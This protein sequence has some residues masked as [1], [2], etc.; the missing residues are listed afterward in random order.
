MVVDSCFESS[1]ARSSVALSHLRRMGVDVASSVKLFVVTH[2]HNDH[3]EGAAEL[4]SSARAAFFV[5]SAALGCKEFMTLVSSRGRSSPPEESGVDEFGAILSLLLERRTARGKGTSTG[6]EWATADRRL[7]EREESGAAPSCEVWSLSPSSASLTLAFQDFARLLDTAADRNRRLRGRS[8]NEY[9][10]V[11]WVRVGE[12]QALLGGDLENSA[13][14]TRGWN[15]VIASGGRPRAKAAGFKIPHHGSLDADN[16]SVWQDLLLSDPV[17]VVTPFVRG[18]TLLP[19]GED[20]ARLKTRTR[21]LYR[22]ADPARWKLPR[23]DAS[24]ERTLREVARNRRVLRGTAGHVQIR[25]PA[26]DGGKRLAV[27]LGGGAERVA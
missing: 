1:K 7:Y 3:I 26:R 12:V 16:P 11:L 2:W 6:L 20:I 15:A 22:T 24:V 25:W 4:F 9:S 19:R 27:C 17:A 13:D 23:R 5:C 14:P 18:R 10:V 21:D 8:P